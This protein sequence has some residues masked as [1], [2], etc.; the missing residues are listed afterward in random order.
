MPNTGIFTRSLPCMAADSTVCHKKKKNLP[1]GNS[2]NKQVTCLNTRGK[3]TR[4]NK[5]WA[6]CFSRGLTQRPQLSLKELSPAGVCRAPK[7]T[8]PQAGQRSPDI[9]SP[10]QR[11]PC[12]I[13]ADRGLD[14]HGPDEKHTGNQSPLFVWSGVI[15]SVCWLTR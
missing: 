13:T 12:L 3:E 5:W 14:R 10:P 11:A 4:M 8:P 9:W 6:W 1:I 7:A 15:K 2:V